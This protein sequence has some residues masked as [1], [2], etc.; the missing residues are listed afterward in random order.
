MSPA[1]ILIVEDEGLIANDI[2]FQLRRSGY[3]VL[4]IASSGEGALHLLQ[5]MQPDLVLMDIRLRGDLDG[6]DTASRVRSEYR[7]PVIF[8]TS[9]ADAET[10]ARAKQVT[11]S[12]YVVKPFRQVNLCSAIE[13]AIFKHKSDLA[14][15]DR[16]AL[17][18]TVLQSTADPMIVLNPQGCVQFLNF[19][20]ERLLQRTLAQCFGCNWTEVMLL[21]DPNGAPLEDSSLLQDME[22]LPGTVIR[23]PDESELA[24]EGAVSPSYADGALAGL[25]ITI[26]D[27]S[28]RREQEAKHRQEQKMVA[29]GRLASGVAHDFNNLLTVIIGHASQLRSGDSSSESLARI[30]AVVDA[31]NTAVGVTRQL[32]TMSGNLV[33]ECEELDVNDR[34]Q[35]LM[36]LMNAALGSNISTS[37]SFDSSTGRIR[38]NCSQFDQ[39]LM[40]L[41]MN[42]RDAMPGGGTVTITT[43][44]FDQTIAGED[45]VVDRYVRMVVKDSGPGIPPATR[46]HIFDPFFTTKSEG[47]NCG[48]GLSIIYGIVKD[49]GGYINLLNSDGCGASFEVLLPRVDA[50]GRIGLLPVPKHTNQW[51]EQTPARTIL[52][53]EDDCIVRE[54]LSSY[55]GDLGFNLIIAVDGQEAIEAADNYVGRIDL[56]L[57][58]VRMPRMDGMAL[59]QLMSVSRPE[60]KALLMSGNV[61]DSAKFTRE[62]RSKVSFI[63]KPFLPPSL[64]ERVNQLTS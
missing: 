30:N 62:A 7:L 16:E 17:L 49:A 36:A 45:G 34:I 55:L 6:I 28:R 53:A 37:T 15:L 14:L 23:R 48:L 31:A 2:A 42:A 56:L 26:R 3:N 9:H 50:P 60:T 10:L 29:L 5:K 38:M 33:L 12:G 8:L 41:L 63:E 39:I 25:V 19:K 20:A 61:G 43:S 46:E 22:L 13:M 54:L 57:S 11:P 24:I 1:K 21:V 47:I 40:N 4:A 44:N 35:R 59:A 58:D 27:V 32:L 18:L 52:L 51:T 64:L